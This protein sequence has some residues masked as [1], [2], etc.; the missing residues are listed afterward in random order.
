PVPEIRIYSYSNLFYWWPVW[1]VGYLF[2]LLTWVNGQQVRIGN[3]D[4]LFHP[5]QHLGLIYTVVFFLV[6]FITNITLRGL[7]SVIAIL[8]LLLITV[9]L[10][11]FGW[12]DDILALLPALSVHMNLG[13]YLFFS[14]LIFLVWFLSVFVYDRLSYWTVR[15]GQITHEHLI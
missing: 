12:W 5:S 15:P 1:A 9:L 7:S 10:A 11:Y 6:I 2:A 13:F 14:T 8:S 3:V 4:E